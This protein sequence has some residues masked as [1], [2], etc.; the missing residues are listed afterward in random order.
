MFIEGNYLA[1]FGTE[2]RGEYITYVDIFDVSNKQIPKHLKKYGMTGRY[3]D[4]RKLQDGYVYLISTHKL[5]STIPWF[6]F[7]LA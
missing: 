6:D 7:W 1:V 2:I 3:F 5:S 4:G